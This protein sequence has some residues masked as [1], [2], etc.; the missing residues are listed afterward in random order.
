MN[1]CNRCRAFLIDNGEV[2]G[3]GRLHPPILVGDGCMFPGVSPLAWCVDRPPLV[4]DR[5]SRT[6]AP[7]VD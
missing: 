6:E 5:A 4:E 2:N 7:H 3:S 1:T